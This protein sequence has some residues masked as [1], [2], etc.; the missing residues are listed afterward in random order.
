MRQVR[1]ET[2]VLCLSSER[3]EKD[4]A[5][6]EAPEKRLLVDLE[7]LQK[8]WPRGK[9]EAPSRQKWWSPSAG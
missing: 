9:A 4:R 7:K 2:H 1:K 3:K 6:R 8:R 5:I